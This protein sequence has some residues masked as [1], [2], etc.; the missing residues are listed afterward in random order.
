MR[1]QW[2]PEQDRNFRVR[3]DQKTGTPVPKDVHFHIGQYKKPASETN[4]LS[5]VLTSQFWVAPQT[6]RRTI[7]RR[8]TIQEA[9]DASFVE[10]EAQVFFTADGNLNEQQRLVVL[11]VKVGKHIKLA[12]MERFALA[13]QN[14]G[15][16]EYVMT[17]FVF[18][19]PNHTT[20]A[21]TS[22]VSPI[23]FLRP[24]R[25]NKPP[26]IKGASKKKAAKP[27]EQI[28]NYPTDPPAEEFDNYPTD[29]PS[30]DDDDNPEEKSGEGGAA[31]GA[32]VHPKQ[33]PQHT[34]VSTTVDPPEASR[35]TDVPM[36]VNPQQAPPPTDAHVVIQGEEVGA[37]RRRERLEEQVKMQARHE[38]ED[39]ADA[40]ALIDA[41]EAKK[42][43][44]KAAETA[45]A[46]K[47]KAAAEKAKADAEKA[48]A[49]AAKAAQ[50]LTD[51]PN[52]AEPEEAAETAATEKQATEPPAKK[53]KT[54]DLNGE[55]AAARRTTLL[56]AKTAKAKEL[57][58]L[59]G[60]M[61]R[62]LAK[63]RAAKPEDMDL[64]SLRLIGDGLQTSVTIM[65]DTEGGS[66]PSMVV[67][68]EEGPAGGGAK[69]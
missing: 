10:G 25:F 5:Y 6:G 53:K 43:A 18:T 19:N 54:R 35:S 49:D 27:A 65:Q 37:K 8:S 47:A 40:Q 24:I 59:G 51:A 4:D 9:L 11:K 44:E 22:N 45:V 62:Y 56:A 61:E 48:K 1:F 55:L 58:A 69:P 3:L 15:Y 46:E 67:P 64:W 34:N 33:E 36:M 52:A 16:G 20:V 50:A 13:M 31:Q 28:E 17:A 12:D 32:A 68:K 26:P 38:K 21:E 39:S 66:L 7:P 29:P 63:I 23:K 30:E 41:A 60:V 57:H 2:T 14:A 42:A